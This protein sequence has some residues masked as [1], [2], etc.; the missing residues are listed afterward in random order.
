MIKIGTFAEAGAGGIRVMHAEMQNR[1][2]EIRHVIRP[3]TLLGLSFH[4]IEGGF[5]HY[6]AVEV[7][8]VEDIPDGMIRIALPA[9][10]YAK[11]EH[12]K[13]QDLDA[14]YNTI[15]A[16]IESRGYKL[17]EGGLT[18]FEEYPMRQDPYSQDPEFVIMIPVEASV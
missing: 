7:D 13:G 1:L 4:N 5:T 14:S 16:W 17:H 12:K 8:K 10:T 2:K 6:A 9:R 15:Y 11:Y 18:H 3:D